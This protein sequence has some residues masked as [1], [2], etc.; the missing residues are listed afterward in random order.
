VA[1]GRLSRSDLLCLKP[2]LSES[3]GK[4]NLHHSHVQVLSNHPARHTQWKF[5][6]VKYLKEAVEYKG[7]KKKEKK[8]IFKVV[9]DLIIS[10]KTGTVPYQQCIGGTVHVSPLVME[11]QND[12]T[13]NHISQ[14][15]F[16]QAPM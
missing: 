7:K 4:A 9:E 12:S 1:A 6:E 3:I 14:I 5:P 13:N 16:V 2:D 8:I 10:G 15:F 11:I